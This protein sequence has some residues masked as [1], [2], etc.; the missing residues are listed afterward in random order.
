M[1]L[2]RTDDA[3]NLHHMVVDIAPESNRPSSFTLSPTRLVAA[4]W[5]RRFNATYS[6][7]ELARLYPMSF[8]A[9][10]KHVVVLERANLSRKG[11]K[12]GNSSFEATSWRSVELRSTCVV[13]RNCGAVALTV[14]KI[15]VETVQKERSNDSDEGTSDK[16]Q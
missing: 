5:K 9:I 6:I 11:A 3:V 15:L 13:T 1:S 14:W 12:V 4:L 2:T 8:A 10:Q 7:S 16:G